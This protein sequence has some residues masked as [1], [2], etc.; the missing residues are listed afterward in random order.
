VPGRTL[1]RKKKK[2]KDDASKKEEGEG[3]EMGGR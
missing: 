3:R 1:K 2:K